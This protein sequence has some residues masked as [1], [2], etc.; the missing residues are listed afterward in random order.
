MSLSLRRLA[1]GGRGEGPSQAEAWRQAA[2]QA[3]AVG[4]LAGRF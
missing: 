3:G 1:T 2:N 4:M